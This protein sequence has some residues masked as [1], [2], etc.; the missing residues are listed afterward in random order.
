[1]AFPSEVTEQF[2]DLEKEDVTRFRQMTLGVKSPAEFDKD[3]RD[4]TEEPGPFEAEILAIP[5]AGPRM[6]Q[7]PA[8]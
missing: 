7:H 8:E 2:V 6:A 3:R 4:M 1:M 5:H